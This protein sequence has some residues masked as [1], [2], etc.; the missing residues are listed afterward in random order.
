[1]SVH[2]GRSTRV[3]HSVEMQIVPI[4]ENLRQSVLLLIASKENKFS[5]QDRKRFVMACKKQINVQ[6]DG[7]EMGFLDN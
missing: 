7:K 3:E 6:E 5:T 1:M 4:G 2:K